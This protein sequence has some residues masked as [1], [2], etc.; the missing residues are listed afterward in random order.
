MPTLLPEMPEVKVLLPL[1]QQVL[2]QGQV[3]EAEQL[4]PL[5]VDQ[6]MVQEVQVQLLEMVHLKAS[7]TT[8]GE[9]LGRNNLLLNLQEAEQHLLHQTEHR[10]G[11]EM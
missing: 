1:D 5:Q 11:K 3:L 10:L 6:I 8:K 2:L 7:L 9:L 4:P